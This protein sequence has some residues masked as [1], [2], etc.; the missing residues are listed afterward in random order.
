MSQIDNLDSGGAAACAAVSAAGTG[1]CIAADIA[2]QLFGVP[3][4]VVM[5]AL[6]GALGARVFLPPTSFWR[7]VVASVGWTFAG[8]FG[9]QFV[10]WLVGKWLDGTAPS[11]AL[12]GVAL[13]TAGLGQRL[14]PILWENGGEALKRKLDGLFKGGD[15]G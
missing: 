5:A 2:T 12:A 3:L 4:P 14:A 7:A 9:S 15:R 8:A 1:L 11:G 13:L 6:T 10:M